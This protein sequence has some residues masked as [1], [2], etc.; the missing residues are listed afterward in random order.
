M[1]R[2]AATADTTTDGPHDWAAFYRDLHRHPELAFHETRTAAIV[3]ERLAALGFEV[4]AGV[5]GTGVVGVL[6][7]AADGTA[8]GPVVL[9]R[10]DMDAL[11]VEE[12][13]ALP[14]AS[15]ARTVTDG[16]TDVPLMHAC[17]HDM[18][19]TCLLG[20]C[21]VLAAARETWAGTLL[22]VFQPAEEIG[23]GARAMIDDGLFE[24]FGRPDVVLGQ[25]VVPMPAGTVGLRVGTAFAAADT[26]RITLHGQGGHGSMPER[27][28]DPVVMAAATVLRLQTVVSREVAPTESAVVTVGAMHAGVV[29]NIIADDAELLVSVR[30]FEAGVRARVHAAI[31]R[32]VRAEAAASGAPRD[33]DIEVTRS[34]AAVVN[35][36]AAA[37]R[38]RAALAEVA[39]V[40]D[41]GAIAGSEDVGLLATASGAPCV[42]WLLGCADPA[43]F[44]G[45]TE[46]GDL[47][48]RV[49]T[50]P[51]NHSARF[52][53]TIEPTLTTGIAT[54][55]AA[56]RAWLPPTWSV[57]S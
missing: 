39:M 46:F 51:A 41:P 47:A 27:A 55:V 40:V 17:G 50:L 2:D 21:A 6:R 4:T 43:L 49:R 23:A 13:T 36:E 52:A 11:P 28:V 30:T 32:I 38:T 34:F 22:V 33:P 45:L 56:A 35:D 1:T 19:T 10:A 54:L 57:D 53:P 48:E 37:E 7:N 18:H 31:G 3:A 12:H 26:L 29:E 44:A 25:H 5:G 24:R 14:H 42:Y 9:L 16:G 8:P 20:A 15:T